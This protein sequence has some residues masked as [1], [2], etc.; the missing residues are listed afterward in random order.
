MA[1]M[2]GFKVL[3]T[4]GSRG[5]GR[6][7][8]E[9]LARRGAQVAFTF[10]SKPDLA[11][12]V[13]KSLPGTGHKMLQMD[14]AAEQSVEAGLNQ[15]L[16]HFG[17]ELHGLVNN[18]GITKD[19]LMLRMKTEDFDQVLATNLRGAFLTTKGSLKTMMKA[20]KGSIVHLSSVIGTTGNAGQA[21]Y[22]ASKG[23]LEAF[24][25]SVALELASR[26]VRSNCVAPGFIATEMTDILTEDQKQKIL[27]KVPLQKIGDTLDV[28]NAVCYLL[29]DEAKY[30]T[31]QTIHVNGGLNM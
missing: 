14:V 11:E 28:A 2:Q 16:E 20:R 23:G 1:S 21:N 10:T 6:G 4:G 12:Q 25:K 5:I 26:N 19:Q 30:I 22:A 7:I 13:L 18:A 17:G 8:V 9:E 24:S 3:V 31:G 29:S 15:V 27:E